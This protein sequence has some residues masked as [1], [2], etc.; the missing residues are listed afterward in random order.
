MAMGY[1]PPL[2]LGCHYL[3]LKCQGCGIRKRLLVPMYPWPIGSIL[4][5]DGF[6]PDACC[7]KCGA[8]RLEVLNE[9]P[10]PEPPPPP[11]GWAKKP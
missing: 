4:P 6:G 9:P 8:A 5:V 11:V 1:E 10:P 7:I 3:Q 2:P